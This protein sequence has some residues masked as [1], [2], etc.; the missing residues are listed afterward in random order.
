MARAKKEK[1]PEYDRDAWEYVT[2]APGQ[3]CSA[4]MRTVKPL[5]PVLRGSIDRTSGAAAVIYRH[6]KCPTAQTVA[7]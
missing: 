6:D 5:D 2:Y 7:P 1:A 3:K 4:C